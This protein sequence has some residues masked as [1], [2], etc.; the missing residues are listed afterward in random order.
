MPSEQPARRTAG[1]EEAAAD[2]P[3]RVP[4]VVQLALRPLPLLPLQP[5][6]AATLRAVL[7]NHPGIFERLGPHAGKRFGLVPMDL[8]LAFLLEPLPRRPRITAVRT[9]PARLDVTIRGSIAALI[10]LVDGGY[11]GDALF[12]SRDLVVEG[13]MEAVVA[14]RNAIDDAQIDLVREGCGSLGPLAAPAERLLRSLLPRPVTDPGA[15][16][17]N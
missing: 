13:D 9:L 8:P 14:L 16:P 15:M 6:L 11:D 4:L 17:W 3:G 1:H 7:A 12:F 10:G 5:I 2:M